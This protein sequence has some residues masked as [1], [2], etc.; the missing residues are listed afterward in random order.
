MT[1]YEK[2]VS[3]GPRFLAELIVDC[4]IQWFE[5]VSREVGIGDFTVD[6]DVRKRLVKHNYEQFMEEYKE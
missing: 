4:K 1:V 3:E 5:S 6:D 2:I